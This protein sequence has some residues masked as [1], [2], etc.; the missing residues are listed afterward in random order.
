[1]W[2]SPLRSVGVALRCVSLSH[3]LQRPPSVTTQTHS[4]HSAFEERRWD[5]GETAVYQLLSFHRRGAQG[6][7][8]DALKR[9]RV[10]VE[11]RETRGVL[12]KK[13]EGAIFLQGWLTGDKENG[14]PFWLGLSSARTW[15]K[16][17]WGTGLEDLFII[18][19]IG[20]GTMPVRRGHVAPQNTFLGVIIRKFEGQSEYLMA[21]SVLRC[22]PFVS[23]S[24]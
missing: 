20:G 7:L 1:M 14:E 2:V 4:A 8:C 24:S 17:F 3:W 12:N 6:S 10:G 21:S 22:L 18:I 13:R 9:A 19:F 5:V 16:A 11:I 23:A 15:R